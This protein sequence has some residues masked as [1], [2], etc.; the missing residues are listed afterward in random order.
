VVV[1]AA[2]TPALVVLA[3]VRQ[4]DNKTTLIRRR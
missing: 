2:V 3:R 1:A 4:E